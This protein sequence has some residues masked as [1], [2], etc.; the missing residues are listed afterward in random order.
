MGFLHQLSQRSAVGG[1][2]LTTSAE[3]RWEHDGTH[4]TISN[5]S[6]RGISTSGNSKHDLAKGLPEFTSLL[7]GGIIGRGVRDN[8]KEV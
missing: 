2:L 4:S 8:K 3:D 5:D 1:L 6:Q 7:Q